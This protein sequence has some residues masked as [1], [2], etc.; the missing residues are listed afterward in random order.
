MGG[1]D[2]RRVLWSEWIDIRFQNGPLY[3]NAPRHV[4]FANPG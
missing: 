2:V 1:R 4:Y 3:R